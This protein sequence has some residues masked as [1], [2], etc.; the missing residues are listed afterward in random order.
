MDSSFDSSLDST[1]ANEKDKG[2]LRRGGRRLERSGALGMLGNPRLAEAPLPG[3][4][5]NGIAHFGEVIRFNL[6]NFKRLNVCQTNYFD[7]SI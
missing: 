5:M 7:S 6:A 1:V 2:H 3:R 4:Y